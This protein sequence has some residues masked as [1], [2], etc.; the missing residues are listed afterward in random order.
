MTSQTKI[1]V[2][3]EPYGIPPLVV[4]PGIAPELKKRLQSILLS[5]ANDPEG[6]EILA[7]MMIDSFVVGDDKNY[8]TIR[9]MNSWV[10]AERKKGK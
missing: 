9:T 2:T 4:R 8:D 10:A 1:I 5:A 6:K 3:S 7:G